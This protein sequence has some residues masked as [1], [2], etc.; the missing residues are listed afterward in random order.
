MRAESHRSERVGSVIKRAI[1]VIVESEISDPRVYG[2]TVAD[3]AVTRELK[4]ATVF[5]YIDGDNTDVL[6]ALSGTA[7]FVRHRLAEMLSEMRYI[8]QIKFELDKTRSYYERID[9]VI[10]RIHDNDE[11]S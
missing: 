5:V 3:V 6:S 8:P 1:S 11:N 10:K 2:V 9:N 7:G 4:Y